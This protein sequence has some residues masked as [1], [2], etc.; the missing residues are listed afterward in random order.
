MF[1]EDQGYIINDSK[2]EIIMETNGS[3]LCTGRSR[4]INVE[5]FFIKHRILKKVK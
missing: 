2:S 1:L 5:Y 3:N 4:H